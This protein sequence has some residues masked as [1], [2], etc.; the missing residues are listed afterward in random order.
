[1]RLVARIRYTTV[2]LIHMHVWYV[3][4]S[5]HPWLDIQLSKF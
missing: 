2:L 5:V 4:D 3:C 1:M